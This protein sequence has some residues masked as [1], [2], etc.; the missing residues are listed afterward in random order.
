MIA[1][2]P[3]VFK[4]AIDK[5]DVENQY[6]GFDFGFEESFNAVIS[7]SVDLKRS[8]LY[9]WDEIYMNHVTDDKFANQPEMQNLKLRLDRYNET[10]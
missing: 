5:L 4:D 2:N 10:V 6:F 9:I 8:I 3:K 1:R 7:M